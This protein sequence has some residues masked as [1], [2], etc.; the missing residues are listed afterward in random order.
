M[1]ERSTTVQTYSVR[2]AVSWIIYCWLVWCERKTLFLAGNLRSFT[3]KRTGWIS[4]QGVLSLH[5]YGF[6]YHCRSHHCRICENRQWYTLTVGSELENEKMIAVGLKPTV[7]DPITT[8]LWLAPAVSWRPLI[9]VGSNQ[10][11]TVIW[12]YHCRFESRTDDDKIA[13]QKASTVLSFLLSSILSTEARDWA[14]PSIVAAALHC[15]AS[16]WIW[17]N[18]LIF[19]FKVSNKHPLLWFCS[20]ISVVLMAT[21]LDSHSSSFF[22]LESTF[23]IGLCARLA[24]KL[25]W[26]HHPKGWCLWTHLKS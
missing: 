19:F 11:P 8:S 4:F 14:A 26:I 5:Y 18:G 12:C 15:E 13:V 25:W 9:T 21:L 24:S 1:L 10:E 3:S 2:Q 7:K 6:E 17:M 23:P 20:L 22:I 16:S